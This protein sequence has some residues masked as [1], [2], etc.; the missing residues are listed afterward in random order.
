MAST[1]SNDPLKLDVTMS[2][3]T[4]FGVFYVVYGLRLITDI[5]YH[6]TLSNYNY[7]LSFWLGIKQNVNKLLNDIKILLNLC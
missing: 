7:Q 1:A 4:K 6:K 2:N 3:L 5:C